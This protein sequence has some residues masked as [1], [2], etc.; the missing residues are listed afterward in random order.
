M[1]RQLSFARRVDLSRMD[2]IIYRI[3]R[4][5]YFRLNRWEMSRFYDHSRNFFFTFYNFQLNVISICYK[6][7]ENP[8]SIFIHKW[9]QIS[10]I[11]FFPRTKIFATS[12]NV[13][14]ELNRNFSSSSSSTGRTLPIPVYCRVC[15][16]KSFGKH[17]GVYCCDGCSCF[18]KR[19]VRRRIIYTC[20]GTYIGLLL[21]YN[22]GR[23][24]ILRNR[25]VRLAG[26]GQCVVDKARRNWCPFC[27]LQKCLRVNMNVAGKY[28][29]NKWQIKLAYFS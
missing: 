4:R 13:L 5:P 22:E 14:N 10:I 1:N 17:Y 11:I 18:F 19:S 7:N 16:D 8:R 6:T 24:N 25:G 27:R 12:H 23:T 29:I 20:I 2:S 21:V 15:G 28:L 9:I 3:C 26:T